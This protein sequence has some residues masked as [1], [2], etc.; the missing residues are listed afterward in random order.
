MPIL[1]LQYKGQA[2][3]PDGSTVDLPPRDEH[4]PRGPC[5]QV[6]VAVAQ[7]IAQ[8]LLHEGGPLPAPRSGFALID[9]GASVT[10][11]DDGTA[12]AMGLPVIDVATMTSASHAATQQNVYPIQI[13]IVGARITLNAD[14]VMGA[15]LAPQGLLLLIGRNALQHGALFYNGPSGELTLSV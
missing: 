10:C 8:Q 1:H 4:I 11:I 12:Q 5:I 7:A 13:E 15:N 3:T 2:K 14:R 6:T 9:T